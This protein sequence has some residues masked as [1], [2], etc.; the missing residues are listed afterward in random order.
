MEHTKAMRAKLAAQM[1]L[2]ALGVVGLGVVQASPAAAAPAPEPRAAVSSTVG[3]LVGGVT[4]GP[5][6]LIRGILGDYRKPAAANTHSG[7]KLGTSVSRL[8]D[9]ILGRPET[10]YAPVVPLGPPPPPPAYDGAYVHGGPGPITLGNV[11]D[12]D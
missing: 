2:P 3:D 7:G 9:S 11:P 5:G 10:Y 12:E 6:G 1:A 4:Y 8:T